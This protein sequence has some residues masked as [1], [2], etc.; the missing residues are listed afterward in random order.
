MSEM[1]LVERRGR[2]AVLT[3]NRPEKRNALSAEMTAEIADQITGL[4]AD[5]AI[6]ALVLTG[7]DPAFCAGFD[8][9]KLGSELAGTRALRWE[10]EK[11]R[12]GLLPPHRKAIIGAI[13]GPAVTGGLELALG[14]DFLIA[15][16]RA[17]FADTHARVGVMPGGGMTIRL[18]ELVG[19][20]RAKRMSLTGEFIDAN[21][22]LAWGLV[23][24]LTS[25]ELLLSRAVELAS[26]IASLDAVVVA[27]LRQMY[28]DIGAMVGYE[29]WI[30]EQAWS[31]KWIQERFD[32]EKLS[33]EADAIIERG[34]TLS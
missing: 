25:H 19:L 7:A 2:V 22:A 30:A 24:E 8:L 16:E 32:Q 10:G 11:R 12:L 31:R 17:S 20:D 23:T 9:R 34:S 27:E 13:N 33:R 18:P 15:S 28:E 14:C 5:D 1:V 29:A 26:S 21:T 4:D 6:G 3:L